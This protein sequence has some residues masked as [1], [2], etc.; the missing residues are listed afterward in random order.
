VRGGSLTHA[1]IIFRSSRSAGVVSAAIFFLY[2]NGDGS[3]PQPR[4]SRALWRRKKILTRILMHLLASL[5]ASAL[6]PPQQLT[7]SQENL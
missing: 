4:I 5:L 1:G 6:T 3:K 7:R 2:A